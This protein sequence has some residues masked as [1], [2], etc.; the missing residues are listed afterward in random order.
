MRY[1]NPLGTDSLTIRPDW[2]FEALQN[3]TKYKLGEFVST[4]DN[5]TGCLKRYVSAGLNYEVNYKFPDYLKEYEENFSAE[6]K[7]VFRDLYRVHFKR[8]R[9]KKI[10]VST[11]RQLFQT[12]PVWNIKNVKYVQDEYLRKLVLHH[13]NFKVDPDIKYAFRL[14][15]SKDHDEVFKFIGYSIFAG[16]SDS[17]LAK[18]YNATKSQMVAVR[19]I[20]FDFSRFPKDRVAKFAYLRQL[21]NIGL[22]SDVDFNYFKRVFEMGE[23]GL[24][25][26]VDFTHLTQPEKLQVRE[27]LSDSIVV[28]TLNVNFAIRSQKDAVTYGTMV[29]SLTD[30]YIKQKEAQFF[31]ARIHNLNVV[32]SRIEGQLTPITDGVTD[33]DKKFIDLIREHSLQEPTPFEYK[34]LDML[35]KT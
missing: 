27:Y 18:R 4:P 5:N 11:N 14:Y 20:F 9:Q 13:S 10:T 35:K 8:S 16:V 17:Q 23:L 2:R 25:A 15:K 30:Y 3:P 33:L 32:T 34:T 1:V 22:F 7:E 29:S 28:N 31:D 6:E 21:A 26:Q 24:R 12:N 19:K